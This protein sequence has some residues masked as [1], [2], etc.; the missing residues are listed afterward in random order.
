MIIITGGTGYIGSHTTVELINNGYEVVIL[1]NLSNSRLEVLDSIEEITG[2][3]PGFFKVDIHDSTEL[4]KVFSQIGEKAKSVI[5]FAAM[6]AVGESVEKPLEYYRNNVGSLINILDEMQKHQVQNLVFSSS[7]TVYGQPDKFP[8]TEE[9]E[10]KEAESPYGNTKAICEDIMRDTSR[11]HNL[12]AI[13]L[14]Y[15]NPVGAH[16]SAKIGELPIG[17]PN[18]LVP[19]VTQTAAGIREHLTIFGVDYPTEDGTCVRDYIHVVDLGK[20]HLSALKRLEGKKAE[21]KYEVF[22][23]GTGNGSSVLQVI[24]AFKEAT[25]IEISY[26]VGDRREGDITQIYA[27]T[28]L[29]NNALGW[30]SELSLEEALRSSWEWEKNYRSKKQ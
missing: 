29:A 4:A 18:N 17:A 22:N 15:F 1:D 11:V 12:N 3:R 26:K 20:A 13:S 5:H 25:G 6:K 19:F 21:S 9:T 27:D 24:Q 7:C 10:R 16:K 2:T 14:R 23:I 8:V 30:K 28:S